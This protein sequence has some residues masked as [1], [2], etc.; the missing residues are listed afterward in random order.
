MSQYK[1]PYPTV[2]VIIEMDD[3]IIMIK[4]KNP[5]VGLAFP[6]G[7]VDAGELLEMAAIREAKEETGL[8]INLI[9][10]LYVYSHPARDP[11]HH[12]LSVTFIA[13]A[14]GNPSAGD[15]ANECLVVDP[16]NLPED[17]VF[18]HVRILEDYLHYKATGKKPTP[19]DILGRLPSY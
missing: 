17:P 11:R 8:E 14:K 15:D 19:S 18:D 12:T 1:N 10:L 2:D 6:G 9:D 7:F 4:R 3:K 5:P 13:S 16:R